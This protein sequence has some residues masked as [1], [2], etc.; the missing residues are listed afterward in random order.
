LRSIHF[1][2]RGSLRV[3]VL[4]SLLLHGTAVAVVASLPVSAAVVPRPPVEIEVMRP[5]PP[6]PKVEPPAPKVEPPAPEPPRARLERPKPAEARPLPAEPSVKVDDPPPEPPPAAASEKPKV[7]LGKVD[8]N[9]RGLPGGDGIAL[10]AGTGSWGGPAPT[11]RKE[12]KPRGSAGDPILGKVEDAKEDEFAL[13]RIGKDEYLYKGKQFSAH[14]L[15]DGTVSFNDKIVRDFNGTSGS[16][17]ITDWIMKGKKQDPYRHEKGRFLAATQELRDKLMR[18]SR[19][20]ELASSL[21][22]L[23]AH[24]EHV[25]SDRRLPGSSRRKMLF[26]IWR[27]SAQS[28]DDQGQAGTEACRIVEAFIRKRLPEGSE[29]AYTPEELAMFARIAKRPFNPYQ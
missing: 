5:P 3:P 13:Q 4:V 6:A 19:Q 9:L 21:A 28:D 24:L 12:W 8:L 11:P 15:P 17:D 23:P 10:P 16:F 2:S 14:I 18:Q 1:G 26:E 29:E 7:D 22:R 27:D 25:W 20:A